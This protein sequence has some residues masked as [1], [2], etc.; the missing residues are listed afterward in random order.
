MKHR[1]FRSLSDT[2]D[3]NRMTIAE[4]R[5]WIKQEVHGEKRFVVVHSQGGYALTLRDINQAE[6]AMDQSHCAA[7]RKLDVAILQALVLDRTLG[8]SWQD[9]AHTP[10]VAY[11]RDEDEAIE[12]VTSGEF[13]LSCLLQNPTVTEVRDVASAGDKMPQK[14]TFFY[15][16]LW[17]GL[18][19]RS[20]K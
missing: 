17:S 7:W 19:L 14:S 8:I 2:F 12:K 18:I 10:D 9:L 4:G 15:P 6:A 11:T 1:L 20:V 16:K 5:S 3:L 13:Q